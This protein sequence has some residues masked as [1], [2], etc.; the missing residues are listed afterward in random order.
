MQPQKKKSQQRSESVQG[1]TAEVQA[2][3]STR[4]VDIDSLL[5]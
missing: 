5:F 3:G 1:F 4:G 2:A